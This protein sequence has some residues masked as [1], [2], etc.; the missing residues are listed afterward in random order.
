MERPKQERSRIS[1]VAELAAREERNADRL[2]ARPAYDKADAI[3]KRFESARARAESDRL[4]DC[5]PETLVGD[6]STELVPAI[7]PS[8]EYS[9]ARLSMV[10]T[11]AVPDVIAVDASEQRAHQA[12]K[13]GVLSSALDTA[14]TLE[15]G[16]TLLQR[17]ER[18]QLFFEILHSALL[19][20]EHIEQEHI[21]P[22]VV[23]RLDGAGGVAHR[24]FG[25]GLRDLFSDE[26]EL[27]RLRP[28]VEGLTV[29]ERDRPQPH[30]AV[31]CLAHVLN[32]FF[33]PTTN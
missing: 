24:Q 20:L 25:K 12:T 19:P 13:L 29:A 1:F 4:R 11:L 18:S 8:D 7:R 28:V 16:D 32:V 15:F 9:P 2:E 21:Q 27:D 3:H 31:A 22:F 17:V 26:A 10:D 6:P 30:H 5:L 23:H 14:K 33:E